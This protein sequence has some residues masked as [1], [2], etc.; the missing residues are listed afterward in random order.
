MSKRSISNISWGLS[1]GRRLLLFQSFKQFTSWAACLALTIFFSKLIFD[2]ISVDIESPVVFV[3][4]IGLGSLVSVVIALPATFSFNRDDAAALDIFF[5]NVKYLGYVDVGDV[6]PLVFC[7]KG[8]SFL[9]WDESDVYVYLNSETVT[10]T[11]PYS[12]IRRLRAQ[13]HK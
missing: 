10:V 9:R 5:E 13:L 6:E 11:G 12:I 3:M 1:L 2:Y 8:P 4:L 7:Q